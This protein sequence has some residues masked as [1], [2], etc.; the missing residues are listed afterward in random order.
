MPSASFFE[1][2]PDQDL[3]I[4]RWPAE[5]GEGSLSDIMTNL[6]SQVKT[7]AQRPEAGPTRRI[8]VDLRKGPDTPPH[9][10]EW[11]YMTMLPY[12]GRQHADKALRAA[13]L[14]GPTQPNWQQLPANE[15][16]TLHGFA[17]MASQDEGALRD[18]L[19]ASS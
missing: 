11:V 5:A 18:W 2:R 10:V 8:L 16:Q 6:A 15:T 3:V 9:L 7:L 12:I 4:L 14:L 13:F 1:L 19:L 17:A